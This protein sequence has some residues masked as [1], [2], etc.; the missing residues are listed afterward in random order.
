VG[1]DPDPASHQARID[2]AVCLPGVPGRHTLRQADL[3]GKPCIRL[4]NQANHSGGRSGLGDAG[5]GLGGGSPCHGTQGARRQSPGREFPV[6]CHG[7]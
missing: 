3:P 5:E 2:R 4:V 7:P 6:D 1:S